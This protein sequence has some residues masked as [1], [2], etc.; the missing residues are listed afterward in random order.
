MPTTRSSSRG[1]G[2]KSEPSCQLPLKQHNREDGDVGRGRGGE[3]HTPSPKKSVQTPAKG[4][5][6]CVCVCVCDSLQYAYSP[7]TVI[8]KLE[9]SEMTPLQEVKRSLHKSCPPSL[10]C[11]EDQL[12]TLSHF[13]HSHVTKRVP[14]AIYISGAPGTG[15]TACLSHILENSKVIRWC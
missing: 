11:R 2:G 4:V 15:K 8:K 9:F 1:K 14:G 6:V 12:H 13:L 3:V 7:H 5:C 10:L